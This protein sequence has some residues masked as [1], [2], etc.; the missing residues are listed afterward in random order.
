MIYF[1]CMHPFLLLYYKGQGWKATNRVRF[2]CVHL[3]RMDDP[4][5]L[6][7]AP[8]KNVSFF[9]LIF[10]IFIKLLVF[11]LWFLSFTPSVL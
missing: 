9:F 5:K 1:S 11:R 8:K 2:I 6:K 4:E 3:F 7:Q 10:N